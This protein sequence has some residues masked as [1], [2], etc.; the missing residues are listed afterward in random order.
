MQRIGRYRIL[1]ELGR[2]GQAVVYLAQDDDLQRKA[3]LKVLHGVDV[4]GAALVKRLERE[5]TIT[6]KL[7]HPG[8]RR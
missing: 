4:S 3:A 8:I 1:R 7:Q 2:G 6:S 5:A